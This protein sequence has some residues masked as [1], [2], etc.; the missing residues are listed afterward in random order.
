MKHPHFP[1]FPQINR[2]S[3]YAL[4]GAWG[5][6]KRLECPNTRDAIS[7]CII[8][9]QRDTDRTSVAPLALPNHVQGARRS[10]SN[11]T[12]RPRSG[13]PGTSRPRPK[14]MPHPLSLWP[15][16]Q[17]I[18]HPHFQHVLPI[19]SRFFLGNWGNWDN[20]A[21]NSTPRGLLTL[22]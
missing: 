16:H 14:D 7:G 12:T 13:A 4:Y 2:L 18:P 6:G 15:P 21:D 22:T 5:M 9:H 1:H 19:Y 17:I 10:R 20:L 3:M 11:L 8:C